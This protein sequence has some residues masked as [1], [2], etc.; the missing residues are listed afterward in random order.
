MISLCVLSC[1]RLPCMTSSTK[2]HFQ[3]WE[4]LQVIILEGHFCPGIS[5]LDKTRFM[6]LCRFFTTSTPPGSLRCGFQPSSCFSMDDACVN[7]DRKVLTLSW[8][9]RVTAGGRE[10][11]GGWSQCLCLS[12][13][14][15]Q[16]IYT[17]GRLLSATPATGV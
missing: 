12:A 5:G 17:W 1:C 15:R 9:C 2:G 8:D 13:L 7:I 16:V 11:A 6:V 4:V 14:T 3:P 10:G